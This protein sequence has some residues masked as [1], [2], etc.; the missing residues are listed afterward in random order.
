MRVDFI[1]NSLID[2]HQFLPAIVVIISDV[3]LNLF[4]I[5]FS[6][7]RVTISKEHDER[8]WIQGFF[9][10]FLVIQEINTLS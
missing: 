2:K 4:D 7:G 3:L 8:R 5:C 9:L 1:I 10:F 6:R